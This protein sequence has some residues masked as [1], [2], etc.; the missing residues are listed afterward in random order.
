MSICCL[1]WNILVMD[2]P[3]EV[4][5]LW[6][7][8]LF[9]LLVVVP[10]KFF[11]LVVQTL[12]AWTFVWVVGYNW[13]ATKSNTRFC[14]MGY[15]DDPCL[16]FKWLLFVFDVLLLQLWWRDGDEAALLSRWGS[17]RYVE[18]AKVLPETKLFFM[19]LASDSLSGKWEL[20][21]EPRA[22]IELLG[23]SMV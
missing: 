5:L 21:I 4:D 20:F 9:G 1:K 15:L 14:C 3:S 11:F 22:L 8:F 12:V 23:W 7:S 6:L 18:G 16:R 19:Q 2:E 13:L 10:I 17:P